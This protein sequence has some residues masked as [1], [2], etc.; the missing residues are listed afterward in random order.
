MLD[1]KTLMFLYLIINV[2]NAGA[3]AIIWSQNRGRFAGISFWLIDMILQAVGSA[4]IVLRGQVPNVI[5]MTLSNTLI[6]AGAL[7][8]FI[9]L[10]RFTGKKGRQIHNYLLLAVFVAVNAYFVVVQPN[11]TVREIAVSAVLAIYTFQSSL[12][13]LRRANPGMRQITR[14]AG[15]SRRRPVISLNRAQSTWWP[16]LH[17][18]S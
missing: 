10:E 12:L 5:S 13:L 1:I 8:I 3:V 11:L 17:T 4:L 9:G 6:L 18:S 15:F 2:V 16:S 7:F 14:L